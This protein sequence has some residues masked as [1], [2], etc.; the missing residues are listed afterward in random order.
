M[1]AGKQVSCPSPP[2]RDEWGEVP[3][4]FPAHMSDMV[5][6]FDFSKE[7]EENQ[8]SGGAA[9]EADCAVSPD[10]CH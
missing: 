8:R 1:A 3:L 2:S 4:P 6:Y 10:V 5:V 7:K 9:A